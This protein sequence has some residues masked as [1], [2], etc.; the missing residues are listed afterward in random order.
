MAETVGEPKNRV[1]LLLIATFVGIFGLDRIYLGKYKSGI[2]KG[3]TLGGLGIWWF[4]DTA[5]IAIDAFS[6]T[7]FG[8][9]HGLVKDATGNELR[10]GFALYRRKDGQWV[11][12]WFSYNT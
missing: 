12:D 4:I 11:K 9:D 3:L 8:K 10:Y 1:I 6:Y 2:I 7:F 5:M